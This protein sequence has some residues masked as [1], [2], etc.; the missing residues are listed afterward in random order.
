ML[1]V[2]TSVLFIIKG[3]DL[4]CRITLTSKFTEEAANV[5][6]WIVEP[7]VLQVNQHDITWS[8]GKNPARRNCHS[9]H[10][11]AAQFLTKARTSV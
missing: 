10:C 9:S 6:G 8:E 11:L 2:C 3:R 7:A 5:E 1:R 4:V